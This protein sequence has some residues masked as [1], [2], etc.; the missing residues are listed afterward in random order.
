[1]ALSKPGH[2][3]SGGKGEGSQTEQDDKTSES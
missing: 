1:M 2:R 3:G